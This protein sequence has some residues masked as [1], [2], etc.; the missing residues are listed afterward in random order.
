MDTY[1]DAFDQTSCPNNDRV[2]NDNETLT[3]AGF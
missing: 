2:E 3:G 1:D